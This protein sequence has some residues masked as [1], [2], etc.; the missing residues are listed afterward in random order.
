MVQDDA[1]YYLLSGQCQ[2]SLFD[3]ELYLELLLV[4]GWLL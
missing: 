3:G 2:E 4:C 1:R